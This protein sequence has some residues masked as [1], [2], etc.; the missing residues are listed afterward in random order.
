MFAA[1]PLAF[2]IPPLCYIRLE[3]GSL[4]SLAKIPAILLAS[5]G[6]IVTTKGAID[7]FTNVCHLTIKSRTFTLVVYFCFIFFRV[8]RSVKLSWKCPTVLSTLQMNKG[9]V[10][11]VSFSSL[12]KIGRL[13]CQ[14]QTGK[15]GN[16]NLE[17]DK[18]DRYPF[19]H[20]SVSK[21]IK[22][23]TL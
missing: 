16:R 13:V 2:I 14:C 3:A 18:Q 23:Y 11:M 20:R 15:A 17:L 21:L 9:I 7:I 8:P 4:T 6:I 1:I 12:I 10:S 19:F 22:C 5:F